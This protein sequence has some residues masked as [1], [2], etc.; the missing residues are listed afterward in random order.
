MLTQARYLLSQ[1]SGPF[2]S[3]LQAQSDI[4]KTCL[5]YLA[6]CR[7]FLVEPA[8]TI[9]RQQI[10][11]EL[12]SLFPYVNEYWL[13]HMLALIKS[14][15][16]RQN[17]SA[18]T[19]MI[20]GAVDMLSAFARD[21]VPAQTPSSNILGESSTVENVELAGLSKEMF[22]SLPPTLQQYLQF[23]ER[24]ASLPGNQG[25]CLPYS[26]QGVR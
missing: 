14:S 11:K 5:Q 10:V 25:T 23:R 2:L 19:S 12:H 8:S 20:Q 6:T 9:A 26:L 13:R 3:S 4:T 24:V 17:S 22:A 15:Q 1:K 18:I 7:I 21:Q 16:T